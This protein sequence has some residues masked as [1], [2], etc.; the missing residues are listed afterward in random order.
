MCLLMGRAL[1]LFLLPS[2]SVLEHMQRN[3]R[4]LQTRTL[5]VSKQSCIILTRLATKR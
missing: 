2:L 5:E 4:Q 1:I 3:K